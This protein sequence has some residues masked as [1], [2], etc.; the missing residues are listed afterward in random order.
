M[1]KYALLALIVSGCVTTPD[2]KS[3]AA[4]CPPSEQPVTAV[5]KNVCPLVVEFTEA[6][7]QT[8]AGVVICVLDPSV[9][10]M[11]C[12]TPTEASVRGARAPES[13]W[14]RDP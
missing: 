1:K 12:M 7:D 4:T 13:S 9:P 14:R 10:A 11:L 3:K 8:Q 6:V 5:I 2:P